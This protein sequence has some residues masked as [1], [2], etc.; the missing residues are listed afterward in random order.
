MAIIG[1]QLATRR[2]GSSRQVS[3][4]V[5]RLRGWPHRKSTIILFVHGY[6]NGKKAATKSFDR[7]TIALAD[8]INQFRLRDV[9]YFHW[10]GNLLLPVLSQLSYPIQL[11]HANESGVLLAQYLR[12]LSNQYSLRS[13]S[14]V[15]HSLGCRVV[16]RAVSELRETA[17]KLAINQ[18]VLMAAAVPEGECNR[19]REFEV[20]GRPSDSRTRYSTVLYS[21]HDAILRRAFVVGQ[22]FRTDR[23]PRPLAVTAVGRFGGPL[24]DRRWASRGDM[25]MKNSGRGPDGRGPYG[26]SDYWGGFASARRVKTALFATSDAR[27]LPSR[28]LAFAAEPEQREL[29][30]RP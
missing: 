8:P 15:A 14:F 26:H 19:G 6:A 7:M 29:Q 13:V 17:P 18:I 3:T 23:I 5:E 2:G 20:I 27:T 16:L 24:G 30:A 12:K 9:F 25:G 11:R 4:H 1:G 22:A 10:P 28:E 21:R